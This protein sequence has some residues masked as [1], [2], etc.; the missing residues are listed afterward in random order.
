MSIRCSQGHV[1]PDNAIF[2]DD[3]GEPLPAAQ[4]TASEDEQ[5]FPAPPAPPSGFDTTV[6]AA[7]PPT[8]ESDIIQPAP[9]ALATVDEEA[10]IPAP[11]PAA[12]SSVPAA[13]DE[14]TTIAAPS[15]PEPTPAPAPAATPAPEP[16][17]APTPAPVAAPAKPHL[18][19]ESSGATFDL[20]GKAVVVIGRED[21]PSNSFPDWD[22]TPYGAED[23]GVSRLHAKLTASGDTWSIEDLESTNFT[24]INRKRIPAKTPTPLNDGDEIRLGR[25]G[26]RFKT[27]A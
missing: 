10:T 24:F 18:V 17:V 14:A 8:F 25:V 5:T 22:L 15:A 2:C 23:G 19:V 27:T 9:E 11:P 3:C 26:L 21:V 4:A 6:Q 16:E 20:A 12:A 13:P 7:N 1:N